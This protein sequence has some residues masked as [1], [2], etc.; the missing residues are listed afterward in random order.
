MATETGG[1]RQMVLVGFLGVAVALLTGEE[2]LHGGE[3]AAGIDGEPLAQVG[4]AGSL[5]G[6]PAQEVLAA[7]EGAEELVVE[8]VA[9]DDDDA[10]DYSL[11]TTVSYSP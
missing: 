3:D 8:V 4:A 10:A 2:L 5:M 11:A 1:R 9:V 6:R 7:G